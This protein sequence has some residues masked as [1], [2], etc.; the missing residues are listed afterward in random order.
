MDDAE[1]PE[2]GS[3]VVLK[4]LDLDTR[5]ARHVA[6]LEQP[7]AQGSAPFDV[8]PDGSWFAYAQLD[9]SDSDLM[10]VEDFR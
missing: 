2:A 1:A 8:A 9:Q 10:L 4:F 5:Q 6:D 3:G 7:P